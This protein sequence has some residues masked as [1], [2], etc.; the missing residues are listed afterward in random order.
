MDFYEIPL[1][2][3]AERFGI[4]LPG[5]LSLLLTVTWR[6]RGGGGWMLDIALA[7]GTPLVSGIPMVTG[8]DLLAQFRHIGI[9]GSLVVVGD[10]DPG[11]PPTFAN[12]GTDTHLYY[13]LGS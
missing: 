9:P 4:G 2:G 3:R 12:L 13:V 5:E 7:D 11:A 1:R 6:N 10:S 8:A